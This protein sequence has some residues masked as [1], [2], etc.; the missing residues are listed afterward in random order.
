MLLLGIDL[1]TSF[2]KVSAVDVATQQCIATA[3]YPE[4][5]TPITSLQP[6]WAEQ[7]PSMWWDH[8]VQAIQ[9]LNA[10]GKF[11]AAD[12]EA[13]GISYQ[14]HGLVIVDKNQKV[15]RDSIIWCDSRAVEIGDNAFSKIGADT[16]SSCLL[17]SPGNFTASKLSWVKENEPEIFK[18]VDKIM[19]PGDFIAMKLTGEITITSS[20]LS[21]GI[22]FDFKNDGISKDVMKHFGFDDSIIPNLRPLFSSHG[23]ILPSIA[24]QLL[25]KENIPVTYKAGDQLNNALSLNVLEPGEVAATAGTSGVIYAVTD[26]LFND[27]YS[28]VNAFAHVNNTFEEKR[29]GVLLCINGTGIMN[30]WIKKMCGDGL[31]YQEMDLLASK[32][33]PGCDGLFILP[34]GNGAERM[35]GNRITGAHIN[36]IDLNKHSKAHIFRAV[37]EGIAFAF[38]YGLDIMRENGLNPSIIR[39]GK[40]NLFLSDIFLQSFVNTTGVA[41]ELYRNDGS[42]GAALGAGIGAG[43]FKTSKEAFKKFTPIKKIEPDN[44]VLYDSLYLEWKKLLN[45]HLKS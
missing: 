23:A 43:I 18:Q 13:I 26:K 14:M 10:T 31:N 9:N 35:L 45:S 39:A 40:S 38:R 11:N 8:T 12:I 22:L 32:I 41:V 25:L 4:T 17:N 16:C 28:R 20:A 37:Q 29:L 2:I 24:K 44:S 33:E 42:V 34:F 1:G 27:K 30:S 19:L 21:E 36:N 5:E 7:S 3:Q 6:G 15:L